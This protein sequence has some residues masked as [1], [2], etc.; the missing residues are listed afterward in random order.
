RSI[1][2][3]TGY[4]FVYNSNDFKSSKVDVQVKNSTIIEAMDEC[5]KDLPL[6]YKVVKNNILVKR[7]EDEDNWVNLIQQKVLSGLVVDDSGEGVPGVSVRLKGSNLGTVTNGA[8][9]YSI[10]VPTETGAL[11]FSFVG[12]VSQEVA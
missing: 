6:T 5:L 12:F 7:E 11:L 2:K 9:R 3:Q 8:G 4:V 10:E 1:K